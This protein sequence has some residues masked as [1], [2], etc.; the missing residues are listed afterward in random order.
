MKIALCFAL[1]ICFYIPKMQAQQSAVS[2][3]NE[4]AES[5]SSGATTI[6]VSKNDTA[7][8]NTAVSVLSGIFT[9][10][11]KG[12]VPKKGKIVVKDTETGQIVGVYRPNSRSG[13]FLFILV[14]GKSYDIRFEN[15][16]TLY[17]SM[18]FIVPASTS[19]NITY[20][21]IDLG[22]L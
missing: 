2:V 14:A 17:K 15:G 20:K 11:E 4:P 1:V 5:S 12:K 8:M 19:F 6:T 13:K 22:V 16:S 10:G 18:H 21:K 9:I 3:G 7:T